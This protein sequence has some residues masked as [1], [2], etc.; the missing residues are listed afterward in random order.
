MTTHRLL[1]DV[2]RRYDCPHADTV[3]LLLLCY[4]E[5]TR[6][7][8]LNSM[9][10]VSGTSVRPASLAFKGHPSKPRRPPSPGPIHRGEMRRRSSPATDPTRPQHGGVSRGLALMRPVTLARRTDGVLSSGEGIMSAILRGGHLPV[11]G[12][13][14]SKEGAF[15]ADGAA[16]LASA[17][18]FPGQR[19]TL[20]LGECLPSSSS[21]RQRV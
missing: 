15:K 19:R 3:S 1:R 8:R 12:G 17:R 9:R 14:P 11:G 2:S 4:D 10:T 6:A 18:V 7:F 13:D 20:R 16:G 21:Q 5:K